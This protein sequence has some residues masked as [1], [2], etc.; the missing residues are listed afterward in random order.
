MKRDL[1][2]RYGMG[3]YWHVADHLAQYSDTIWYYRLHN[4]FPSPH[5][6][7]EQLMLTIEGLQAAHTCNKR[8]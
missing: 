1:V 8:L 2:R 4:S 3:V 7:P 6:G 5:T